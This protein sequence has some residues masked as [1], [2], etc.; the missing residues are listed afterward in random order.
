MKRFGFFMS[1]LVAS[2]FFLAGCG[3]S[4]TPVDTDTPQSIAIDK[5]G[6]YAD[7]QTQPVPT[8]EDYT[9]A[10]VVGVTADNLDEMN[11]LVASLTAED[12]DTEEKIQAILD[13]SGLI[14]IDPDEPVDTTAPVITML[15]TTPVTVTQGETY[16]DAGAT[17]SDDVD[18]DI[19]AKI[20][21]VNSVDNNTVG[22]YTV[23]YNVSDA[24]GNGA[25][26]VTREVNVISDV[27][28]GAADATNSNTT[29]VADPLILPVNT[30]TNI[31]VT[32]AD[33]NGVLLTTGGDTVT[34]TASK[35]NSTGTITGPTDNGNGTYTFLATQSVV[36]SDI[37]YIATVNGVEVTV[38]SAPVAFIVATIG[39]AN[40]TTSVVEA[41]T[42]VV[43]NGTSAT[44]ITV[45]LKDSNGVSLISGGAAVTMA[46]TGSSVISSVVDNAN[47]TYTFTATNTVVETVTYTA[48]LNGEV[49]TDTATVVFTD[50]TAPD[51]TNPLTT[52]V[53]VP[54]VD[55]VADGA[56]NTTITV[57]LVDGNG[58]A[59]T[60]GDAVTL[61]SSS[62]TSVPSA[63][64]DN[65]NGTYTFTANNTVAET[66]TYTAELNGVN[67]I[68]TASV[69]FV[70]GEPD[71]SESNVT[72]TPSEVLNDGIAT[73]TLTVTLADSNG[74][75]I[76]TADAYTVTM[77]SDSATAAISAVTANADGTYTFT[78]T[79]TVIE[80]VTFTASVD[81]AAITTTA[82]VLFTDDPVG[83]DPASY[84]G[85]TIVFAGIEGEFSFYPNNKFVKV[86]TAKVFE[87]I[88]TWTNTQ[89]FDADDVEIIVTT[90]ENT[91]SPI[92][93]YPVVADK[94]NT[95]PNVAN[96]QGDGI[97]EKNVNGIS[98]VY[99]RDPDLSGFVAFSAFGFDVP[100]WSP[101]GGGGHW[102]TTVDGKVYAYWGTDITNEIATYAFDREPG[103]GITGNILT[104][105]KGGDL[106]N[107]IVVDEYW[108]LKPPS[109]E[110]E[111]K[112]IPVA[113][114][115]TMVQETFY[116]KLMLITDKVDGPSAC[117]YDI[118]LAVDVNGFVI[119][120]GI[121][122]TGTTPWGSKGDNWYINTDDDL[123]IK[124]HYEGPEN[125][126]TT[127]IYR[128]DEALPSQGTLISKYNR[129]GVFDTTSSISR[130]S[131]Y[132]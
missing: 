127:E 71:L 129:E 9:D 84:V 21:T 59:T 16:T 109:I 96:V 28:A 86:S 62:T 130:F 8:V 18:G 61:I 73:A 43:A 20:V 14:I 69:V 76:T 27:V 99:F 68:N 112:L 108:Q 25:A 106:M 88:G 65:S 87:F 19:T 126:S 42:P 34:L 72:G 22:T 24:A 58:D 66:V 5:I 52:V 91:I 6:A 35:A 39:E 64:A 98:H 115:A 118:P 89:L 83:I 56:T 78:A 48:S 81:G 37:R 132:K 97:R 57:T 74:N 51:I 46:G 92:Y 2:S 119:C 13:D 41:T 10:G 116:D 131:D 31:T 4:S 125:T 122:I 63:A 114:P 101:T 105:T 36:K 117:Y 30:D 107:V 111:D 80:T 26:T 104:V 77:A 17:A 121:N 110:P 15:G 1:L 49:I 102:N 3:G 60:G 54:A 94:E 128:F 120:A 75:T 45:T 95:D 70:A 40:A 38:Q 82:E 7:D 55:V 12:V 100:S 11:A 47:G 124:L 85:D 79:N 53:A 29:V 90:V 50:A 113:V 123:E 103:I 93:N 23:T 32:L 67:S 33:S 44:T